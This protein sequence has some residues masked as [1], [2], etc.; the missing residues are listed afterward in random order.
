M[1]R[2]NVNAI[3]VYTEVRAP[4]EKVWECWTEPRHIVKWNQASD[5]WHSPY[6]ENDLGVSGKFL[7]RME[8][9]DGSEGFDFAGVYDEVKPKEVISYTMED[10]REVRITFSEEKGKVRVVETFDPEPVN[11]FD[12][13]QQ[14][15]QAILDSF[16][17]YVESL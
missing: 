7:Y 10:A 2:G 13:Q 1:E 15:W 12:L 17:N 11:P 3:T 4:L 6:A 16:K 14:G 5:D 9:R 8:A